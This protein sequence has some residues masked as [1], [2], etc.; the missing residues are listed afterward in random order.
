MK[1]L[2]KIYISNCELKVPGIFIPSGK[3]LIILQYPCKR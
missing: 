2:F 1:P 3:K